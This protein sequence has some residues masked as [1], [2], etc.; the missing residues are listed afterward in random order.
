MKSG[1]KLMNKV[2][3]FV[4][5][6]VCRIVPED[7]KKIP[8]EGPLILVGNHINFLEVPVFLPHIDHPNVIGV[9]KRESWK[10]PLFNFLFKQWGI[11]PIDRGQVDREAFR[12]MEEALSQGK[13]VAM[14]PE[15]T[16]SKDGC[17]LPGKP[18]VVA[19]A[20]KSN[21]LLLPI[22]FYGYENF[23]KNFKHF[24]KTDFNVV[25]GKPFRLN[26]NGLA[27]SRDVRQ[28]I[29]DEIM[30]KIA[31]LLP[32]RYRGHY[33]FE[34]PIEYQYLKPIDLN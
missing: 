13:V 15:G 4:F 16:R 32:E 24:K 20:V 33:Q 14:S 11:I 7:F 2:L 3:R 19:I 1:F 17:L 28:A 26:L 31:E 34:N 23:W 10:N 5:Q 9:A 22:G 27:L 12:Q 21:A 6:I 29:T 25:V 18:G 8:V 30:Y